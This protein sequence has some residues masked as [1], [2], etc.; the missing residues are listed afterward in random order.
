[1]SGCPINGPLGHCYLMVQSVEYQLLQS[2]R[3]ENIISQL[4]FV[5]DNEG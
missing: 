1:M 3:G 5:E 4:P 2:T